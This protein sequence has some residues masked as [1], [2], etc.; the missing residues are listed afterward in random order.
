M[1]SFDDFEERLVSLQDER[2]WPRFL[3][4][5][6]KFNFISLHAGP[7]AVGVLLAFESS[8]PNE[9]SPLNAV[10]F[11][12]RFSGISGLAIRGCGGLRSYEIEHRIG[13]EYAAS[14][15]GFDAEIKFEFEEMNIVG[16]GRFTMAKEL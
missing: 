12:L 14:F 4:L 5:L 2:T 16:D 7:D 11:S 10:K 9:S 13:G 8:A 1:A 6:S 3:A 15:G